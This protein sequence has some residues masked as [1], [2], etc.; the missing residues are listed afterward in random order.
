MKALIP[1]I[2][3]MCLAFSAHSQSDSL[4]PY[5]D[6]SLEEL[7]QLKITTAGKQEQTITDIPA[8]V[9][10]ISRADIEAY[11]YQSLKEILSNLL[12]LYKIDDYREPSFGVRGFFSNVYTRNIIFMINGVKQQQFFQNWNDLNLMNIQVESI[13][14]IEFV[15]GPLSIIYGSDAFF[16]A[17]N[18]FTSEKNK[19]ISSSAIVS[20]GSNNTYRGNIQINSSYQK[21]NFNLSAG[22]YH[23]DG[24]NVPFNHVLDSLQ[25][26][27]KTWVKNGVTKNFFNQD[28]KYLNFDMDHK[29]FYANLTYD[30]TFRNLIHR[31][32]P[33]YDSV[34]QNRRDYIYRSCL[35]YRREL[36]SY[37]SFDVN[38]GFQSM[39]WENSVRKALIT[40]DIEYGSV[41]VEAQK[42][43]TELI[44]FIK[45]ID[46][47]NITLGV[48]YTRISNTYLLSDYPPLFDRFRVSLY[49]PSVSSAVFTQ[50]KYNIVK[51]I[52]L[53]FGVRADFQN[54][55]NFKNSIFISDVYKD[56]IYSNNDNRAILIPNA[57]L[58]YKIDN[59]KVLKVIYSK[60][61]SRPGIVENSF[62]NW[63][64]QLVLVP[65]TIKSSELNYI[66]TPITTITYSVSLFYNKLDKLIN[67]RDYYDITTGKINQETNNTGELETFGGELQIIYKPLKNLMFD[68]SFSL[69]KT[70]NK[71]FN[72]DAAYSPNMLA[73]F[74]AIYTITNDI[75]FSV[76]SYSVG[77]MESQWDEAPKD[78]LH[79]DYTPKGRI[80]KPTPAY[81]NL[82]V[83]LRINNI[84]KR[85]FFFSIHVENI[86]NADIY[87]APT[88]VNKSYLAK[89][90]LDSG[91]QINSVLGLKF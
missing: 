65:Q 20:Y 89:G 34:K 37:F 67:R 52:S 60:A 55:Y 64:P 78:P 54:K 10:V 7:M 84:F 58:I 72:N 38:I 68:A 15:R 75:V 29:G 73:Y 1:V 28:S 26:F 79:G 16:G 51:S 14:K 66:S 83:N 87:Y 39:G 53:T 43:N 18:I 80:Y 74:K 5:F 30:E 82:G 85:G 12:G 81:Y 62:I 49:S 69:Q 57:T 40:P 56:T 46:N 17:I 59:N 6:M 48:N 63:T 61:I 23:T 27:D 71:L 4:M 70:T 31:W 9:V 91:I 90:T 36:N 8:S 44:T 24:R 13:E 3:C 22:F 21:S 45:P 33:I 19:G 76:S 47:I 25:Q 41:K 88:T 35:G 42:I 50:I 77:K 2:F 86:L 11:G 32:A